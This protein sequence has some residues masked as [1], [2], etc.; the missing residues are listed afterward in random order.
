MKGCEGHS[1]IVR[2]RIGI[3]GATFDTDNMGVSALAMGTLKC[4]LHQYPDAEVFHLGYGRQGS[5][6]NLR[7]GE[8]RVT[9]SFVNM[10]FSKKFYLRNNIAMLLLFALALKVIPLKSLRRK[11]IAGNICLKHIVESDLI[12]TMAGGD[13]FSDIYGI[14]RLLATTLPQILIV[15][16]GKRLILVPQTIGPFKGWFARA[17]ARYIL[18]HADLIYSRDHQ[19]ARDAKSL[20]GV[21]QDSEKVK[22]CYDV[23]FVVDPEPPRDLGLIGLPSGAKSDRLLVG[24]NISGL[25][26]M[27]GLNRKNMF[28]LDVAYDKLVDRLVDFLIQTKGATVLIVPHV[29]GREGESDLPVCEK[30]YEALKSR[31][32][33]SIALARECYELGTIKY[34]IGACDFFIGARMHACIAAASQNVPV[35]PMAYSDKFLGVMQTI[36][37]ESNVVDLRKMRQ[38]EILEVVDRALDR[39]A[40][41]RQLLART[42]PQVKETVLRLFE[43]VE[44]SGPGFCA[45]SSTGEVPVSA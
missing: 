30:I 45:S 24:L 14:E 1:K 33:D 29:F 10:R 42:M 44:F 41:V 40:E 27:G 21:G 3:L 35:V 37:I 16:L 43:D 7:L 9:I 11:I 4:I 31:F 20:I 18:R 13:S 34:V 12:A 5:T 6:L 25:L 2:P 26:W 36:G 17:I 15:L 19:G 32:G 28:G 22:F 39:R 23:G 38:E 8:K